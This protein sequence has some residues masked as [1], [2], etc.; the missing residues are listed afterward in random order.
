MLF[1]KRYSSVFWTE[2]R[3]SFFRTGVL[4][5][6]SCS[7]MFCSYR[8]FS[9]ESGGCSCCCVSCCCAFCCRVAWFELSGAT[10]QSPCSCRCVYPT[11]L[12]S[13]QHTSANL[14]KKP[15][16]VRCDFVS[17]LLN[18]RPPGLL[19]GYALSSS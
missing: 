19:F 1:A 14:H 15:N 16:G 8:T 10:L 18:I 3:G 9:S 7:V 13:I 11:H 12:Y 6:N 2:V 5:A 17:I 4:S